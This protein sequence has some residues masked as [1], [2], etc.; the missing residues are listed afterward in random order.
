[1]DKQRGRRLDMVVF[2]RVLGMGGTRR[3]EQHRDRGRRYCTC[4]TPGKKG[5]IDVVIHGCLQERQG[6]LRKIARVSAA[7]AGRSLIRPIRTVNGGASPISPRGNS[8]LL[9]VP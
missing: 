3:N 8:Y 6:F 1:M 5:K 4:E 2:G 7:A 9:A